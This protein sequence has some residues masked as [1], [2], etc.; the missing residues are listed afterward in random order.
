MGDF[1]LD[2]AILAIKSRPNV[3]LEQH[4]SRQHLNL[5]KNQIDSLALT[6]THPPHRQADR[7]RA[8]SRRGRDGPPGLTARARARARAYLAATGAVRGARSRLAATGA[9][10]GTRPGLAASG[11]E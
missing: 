9:G 1:M 8:V 10:R 5:N 7:P 2:A 11:A 4:L 3:S 6:I